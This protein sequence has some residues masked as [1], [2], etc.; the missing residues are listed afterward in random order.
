MLRKASRRH[1]F[2]FAVACLV[3]AVLFTALV[4]GRRPDPVP[5]EPPVFDV[6]LEKRLARPIPPPKFIH[7]PPPPESVPPLIIPTPPP[8]PPVS[9]ADRAALAA[10]PFRGFPGAEAY[11]RARRSCLNGA[12]TPKE[13][14]A[15]D[16]LFGQ[17]PVVAVGPEDPDSGFAMAARRKEAIV[18]YKAQRDVRSYPGLKCS[19]TDACAVTPWEG[20]LPGEIIKH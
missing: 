1:A 9:D 11:L 5:V 18:R 2:A 12:G 16:K 7:R 20:P 4:L 10:A 6:V 3:H 15:C 19:L 13:E 8:A 14:D 17:G